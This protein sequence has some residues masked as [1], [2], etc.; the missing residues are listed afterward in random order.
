MK[1]ERKAESSLHDNS[2]E[3]STNSP[4]CV[5]TYISFH[6]PLEYL[7]LWTGKAS[8]SSLDRTIPILPERASFISGTHETLSIRPNSS[9]CL[10]CLSINSGL[11]STMKY[12]ISLKR[13]GDFS[14][15]ERRIS[16]HKRPLPAP[17]ST[18]FR[19]EWFRITF[20]SSICLIIQTPKAL[21]TSVLV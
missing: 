19:G 21:W 14:L 5:V 15:A 17:T 3:T 16:A 18:T 6:R 12:L 7:T 13:V 2:P 1:D 11:F 20:I 10:F 9:I 4:L 8:I